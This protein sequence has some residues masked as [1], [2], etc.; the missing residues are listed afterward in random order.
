MGA[1]GISRAPSYLFKH[2]HIFYFRVAVPPDIRPLLSRTEFRV[3]LKT[4]YLSEARV[5]AAR[6]VVAVKSIFAEC[7]KGAGVMA[8]LTPEQINNLVAKWLRDT[9]QE[10]EDTRLHRERPWDESQLQDYL[11]SLSMNEGDCREALA[12]SDFSPSRSAVEEIIQESGL[13]V[14]SDSLSWR[15]LAREA[16]KACIIYAQVEQKRAKGEYAGAGSTAAQSTSLTLYSQAQAPHVSSIPLTQLINSFAQ[17]KKRSQEWSTPRSQQAGEAK[18]A[19]LVGVLGDIGHSQITK[20]HIRT[21]KRTLEHV[22]TRMT[23]RKEYRDKSLVEILAMNIPDSD[24]LSQGTLGTYIHVLN[25]FLGWL[26]ANYDGVADGLT[27]ILTVSKAADKTRRKVVDFSPDDLSKLFHSSEYVNDTFDQPWKFWLMP[28]LLFTGARLEEICQLELED[29][30][31]EEGLWIVDINDG[32]GKRVKNRASNRRVPLHP[33]LVDGL[34]LPQYVE[35][36][37]SR[38]ETRLFPELPQQSGRFSHYPSRWFNDANIGYKWWVGIKSAPEASKTLHSFRHTFLQTCDL[39]GI[40]PRKSQ[41]ITG[42][43]T[44]RQIANLDQGSATYNIYTHGFPLPMLYH[45]V[46]EKL[47]FDVDLTHLSR[48]RFVP[49]AK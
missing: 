31:Q 19:F 29:I 47:R 49:S 48:S 4:A 20:E 30:R 45:D 24:K 11:D 8:E 22:P 38:K 46:V 13:D 25:D 41:Q 39:L 28:I 37:R 10:S 7:R 16:L 14:P 27:G 5:K 32:K 18:L 35:Q 40:P 12:L 6:G 21:V 23:A 44:A 1:F 43:K 33:F 3:S 26:S 2:R 9:L 42:H 17:E 15:M 34:H 36:L